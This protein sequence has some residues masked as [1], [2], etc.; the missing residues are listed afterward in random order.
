[1]DQGGSDTLCVKSSGALLLDDYG[2]IL[3]S[4][5]ILPEK[6]NSGIFF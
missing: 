4:E 3:R 5:F 6:L 2:K 1:M